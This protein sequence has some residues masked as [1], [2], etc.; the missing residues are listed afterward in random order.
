MRISSGCADIVVLVP[1]SAAG[2]PEE[3]AGD[4]AARLPGQGGPADAGRALWHHG[5]ADH[6]QS[7]GERQGV[8]ARQ[9]GTV[10]RTGH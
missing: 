3:P 6:A 9:T 5:G 10:A 7:H 4:A 2:G 1:A 8:T